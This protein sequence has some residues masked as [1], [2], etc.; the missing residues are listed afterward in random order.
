[1]TG[2]GDI[3]LAMQQVIMLELDLSTLRRAVGGGSYVRGAEY[4][5]QQAVLQATWD[6]ED[7]ALRGMVR[8]Q[9]GNVYQTAAFFSLADG[10]PAEFE[11]GECSC[12]VEFNC[13]HVVALVLSALEPGHAGTG[14]AGAP[15]PPAWEQSLDSLLDHGR[16]RPRRHDAAG[17]RARAGRRCRA[18]LAGAARRRRR[19][20]CG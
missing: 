1:M 18:S 4:A 13:K 16:S 11:T 8:G 7:T 9:G 14:P 17:D 19:R 10:R 20:R 3:V 15:Q 2:P 12:P 5:R 6:P